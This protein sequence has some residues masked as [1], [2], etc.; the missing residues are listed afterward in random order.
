MTYNTNFCFNIALRLVSKL[1]I[2]SSY[3][4]EKQNIAAFQVVSKKR[5]QG[6]VL[7]TTAVALLKI[8]EVK[9]ESTCYVISNFFALNLFWRDIA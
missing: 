9:F 8:C 5:V 7:I 3:S 4:E 6:A 2:A 1:N